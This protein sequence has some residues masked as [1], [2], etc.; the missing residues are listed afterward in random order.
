M[1]ASNGSALGRSPS[2]SGN[3]TADAAARRVKQSSCQTT[4][5]AR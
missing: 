3:H 5:M 4:T 1:E 2:S